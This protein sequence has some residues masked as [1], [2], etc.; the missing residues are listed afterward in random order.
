M[1]LGS[2]GTIEIGFMVIGL[3][4]LI[5]YFVNKKGQPETI[6][7]KGK[8]GVA[9]L[10]GLPLV[11]LREAIGA[12]YVVGET[13]NIAVMVA[14]GMADLLAIPGLVGFVKQLRLES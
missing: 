12:G 1:D 3:T 10:V 9:I 6:D 7:G 2:I 8:V 4:Q 14:R 11:A 5:C 13:A